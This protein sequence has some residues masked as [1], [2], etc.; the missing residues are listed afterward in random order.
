VIQTYEGPKRSPQEVAILKTNV[1]EL[2]LDTAWID[3]VDGRNLVV[4]YSEIAVL[5]GRR[6][7][8]I[9]VSTG[10]FKASGTVSFEARA[11][12]TYRVKGLI[13]RG[14]PFAWIEDDGTGETV[15]GEKP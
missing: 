12:R 6:S 8:R 10:M 1:T 13:R 9:Q 5:P 15:A 2:T 3:V 7:V 4:A 14:T 11:G